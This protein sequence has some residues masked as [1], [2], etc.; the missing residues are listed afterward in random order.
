MIWVLAALAGCALLLCAYL[1]RKLVDAVGAQAAAQA[2]ENFLR[3]GREE[4]L[5][6]AVMA[7]NTGE[8]VQLQKAAHSP[9]ANANPQISRDEFEADIRRQY[10]QLTGVPFDRIP[11]NPEGL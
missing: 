7:R 5:L 2:N 3:A 1:A 4:L 9:R 8:V 10:E 11:E 6:H